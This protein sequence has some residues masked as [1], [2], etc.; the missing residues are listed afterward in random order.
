MVITRAGSGED[1]GDTAVDPARGS[2]DP[3]ARA[4][5]HPLAQPRRTSVRA[6]T[7]RLMSPAKNA[8]MCDTCETH[9]TVRNVH[10][11]RK[12]IWTKIG[13]VKGDFRQPQILQSWDDHYFQPPTGYRSS[14][15]C[16]HWFQN[17]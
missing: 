9:T 1:A 13:R 15:A 10:L 6:L 5:F 7:H 14:S 12:E 17:N 4:P 16:F 3:D 2:G 8:R 11:D